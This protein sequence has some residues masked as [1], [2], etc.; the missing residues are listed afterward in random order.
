[1]N[2]VFINFSALYSLTNDLGFIVFQARNEK[3][4]VSTLVIRK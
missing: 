2:D 4:V 3:F 1:M